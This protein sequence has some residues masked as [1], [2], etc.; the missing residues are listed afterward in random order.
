M[1]NIRSRGEHS[2]RPCVRYAEWQSPG[3]FLQSVASNRISQPA[4]NFI[5]CGV[6]I[7]GAEQRRAIS[8]SRSTRLRLTLSP[9]TGSTGHWLVQA[10]FNL[11][12]AVSREFPNRI[13][14]MA[15]S[16]GPWFVLTWSKVPSF[17][18]SLS[19]SLVPCPFPT[20]IPINVASHV[21]RVSYYTPVPTLHGRSDA[22]GQEVGE[23]RTLGLLWTF[24]RSML[25]YDGGGGWKW[26]YRGFI[27]DRVIW[28]NL[29][30][31]TERRRD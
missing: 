2:R 14:W 5:P 15:S 28:F 4:F 26:Q 20:R 21:S 18:L 11:V 22:A 10:D 25:M 30:R 31:G 19:L 6:S 17:S 23:D 1:P 7:I 13:D 3:W 29:A 16:S 27:V 8:V 12:F 9:P 24:R